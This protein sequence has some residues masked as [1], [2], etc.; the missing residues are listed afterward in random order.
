MYINTWLTYVSLVKVPLSRLWHA[1]VHIQIIHMP[2]NPPSP[3]LCAYMHIHTH[4]AHVLQVEAILSKSNADVLWQDSKGRTALH[5]AAKHGHVGV[6]RILTDAGGLKLLQATARNGKTPQE[7][8]AWCGQTE[9]EKVLRQ[10]REYLT[11]EDLQ[12]REWECEC[13]HQAEVK[14]AEYAALHGDCTDLVLSVSEY[15]EFVANILL[16]LMASSNQ[17][18]R[19]RFVG[20]PTDLV[21]GEFEQAA[22]GP[23][24]LL[25]VT[26]NLVNA[27]MLQGVAAIEDEV[28]ALGDK[29]VIEQLDYILWRRAKEKMCS[30][31]LR[32]KGHA[33]MRLKDFMKHEHAVTAELDDAELVALRLYTTSAFQQIN[34]PLRDQERIRRGEPHPLPVTVMLITEGI[35]KLRAIDAH[36]EKATQGMVLWR[37]MKNVRPTDSFADKGGTEVGMRVFCMH[38]CVLYA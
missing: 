19:D 26:K 7:Y 4:C 9:V 13:R 14:A 3:K 8:A 1:H 28:K 34:N 29:Q 5:V 15:K 16:G 27:A 6:V 35:K 18:M 12:Q 24:R 31:G 10:L 33:G 11:S 2:P 23:Y 38:E 21:C 22:K 25:N 17:E 36:N 20:E 37:G 32:D 30:K